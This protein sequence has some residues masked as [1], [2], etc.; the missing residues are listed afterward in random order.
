[1]SAQFAVDFLTDLFGQEPRQLLAAKYPDYDNLATL[2][3]SARARFLA[4]GE[5]LL[6]SVATR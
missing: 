1:M 2:I 5:E 6:P 4:D 3:V